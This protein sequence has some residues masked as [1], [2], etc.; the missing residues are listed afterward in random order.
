MPPLFAVDSRQDGRPIPHDIQRER[1]REQR[2]RER[3]RANSLA[4]KPKLSR[5]GHRRY[6]DQRL[7]Y[8]N[9]FPDNRDWARGERER[10]Q[11]DRERQALQ[12]QP[13]PKRI[14]EPPFAGP[15]VPPHHPQHYPHPDELDP[16]LQHHRSSNYA[17]PPI[18]HRSSGVRLHPA[19]EPIE[20][21]KEREF[22]AHQM[23]HI[24][25]FVWPKTPFPFFFPSVTLKPKDTDDSHEGEVKEKENAKP[26]VESVI[27]GEKEKESI[28]EDGKPP[29]KPSTT[30]NKPST[31][32]PPTLT[33]DN[34]VVD[35]D[36]RA[37]IYIPSGFLPSSKLDRPVGKIWGGGLNPPPGRVLTLSKPSKSKQKLQVNGFSRMRKGKQ[38][39]DG[40]DE[41]PQRRR[42]IYTDDSDLFLC[43]LHSG[44]VTWSGT[45][46]AKSDGMDLKLDVRLLRVEGAKVLRSAYSPTQVPAR[47]SSAVGRKDDLKRLRREEVITQF[48]GGVGERYFGGDRPKA[49]TLTEEDTA[50]DRTIKIPERDEDVGDSDKTLMDVDPAEDWESDE[51]DDGRGIESCSWGSGHDGSGI[52]IVSVEFVKVGVF[53]SFH[54]CPHRLS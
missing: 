51:E 29:L 48:V 8:P 18:P 17:P 19:P 25:S 4:T 22:K 9:P 53:L 35:T 32:I 5:E 13:P 10:E 34:D 27:N 6:D 45:S 36:T 30:P 2:D 14:N 43:A 49:E 37:T 3:R 38:K 28:K 15:P 46:K 24:G 16:R 40:R 23:V 11:R 42:R 39:E 12:Q 54:P 33:S 44:F 20:W 1:E 41:K 21:E 52:E 7:P 31:P 47:P 50:L 26:S